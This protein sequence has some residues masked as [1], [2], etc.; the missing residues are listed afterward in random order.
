MVSEMVV[1]AGCMVSVSDIL[2]VLWGHGGVARKRRGSGR[3]AWRVIMVRLRRHRGRR[4]RKVGAAPACLHP[5]HADAPFSGNP[6]PRRACPRRR[7]T[8]TSSG[9]GAAAGPLTRSADTLDA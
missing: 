9:S 2:S 5:A 3:K 8:G 4:N 1:R 6:D 7:N